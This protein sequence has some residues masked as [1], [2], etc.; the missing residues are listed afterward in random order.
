M[1]TAQV[2][3]R[4]IASLFIQANLP[5]V[6]PYCAGA[7]VWG[8]VLRRFRSERP[9]LTV[10]LPGCGTGRRIGDTL[11]MTDLAAAVIDHLDEQSLGR[12]HLVT[13]DLAGLVGLLLAIDQ[14]ERVASLTIVSSAWAAPSGDGVDNLTLLHPPEPRWSSDSQR[15]AFER[16]SYSP[17]AIGNTL[18]AAALQTSAGA[19]HQS[20]LRWA[21]SG[22]ARKFL[23][24][25]AEAK[26]RF[27]QCAR[28]AG[29]SV[30]IQVIATTDDALVSAD[31]LLALFNIAR[32]GQA[33]S[34]FHIM[35]RCGSL[36]FRDDPETFFRLVTSF[37]DGLE[38]ETT[39]RKHDG[40]DRQR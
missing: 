20:A 9:S 25:V 13:H 11:T 21:R 23:A 10:D 24:S 6:S 19:A 15:W 14:P 34:H 3:P 5:G 36:P 2:L 26:A 12:V 33:R 31:H 22:G 16:L 7:H 39:G 27:Y 17:L 35:N 29:L 30:P 18:V 40:D 8:D 38:Q 28:G 4:S 37:Q 1:T 32:A